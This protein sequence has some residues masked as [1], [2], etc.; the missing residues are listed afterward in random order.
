MM[1]LGF[2]WDFLEYIEIECENHLIYVKAL[3]A[4][5]KWSEI[6]MIK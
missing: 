4:C 5:Q 2:P 1:I 3:K 6:L